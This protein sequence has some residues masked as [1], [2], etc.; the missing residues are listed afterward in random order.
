VDLIREEL[1][2]RGRTVF[3]DR[4]EVQPGQGLSARIEE[5]LRNST[6]FVVYYS[7]RYAMRHAC[8]FELVHAYLADDKEGGPG[9]LMVINPENNRSHIAPVKLVDRHNVMV[10]A[11]D[12]DVIAVFRALSAYFDQDK[13]ACAEWLDQVDLD[14]LAASER[15][16]ITMVIYRM[17][18]NWTNP[19]SSQQEPTQPFE[20][21][22]NSVDGV[23]GHTRTPVPGTVLTLDE[24]D[25]ASIL[26]GCKAQSAPAHAVGL[27]QIHR[28]GGRIPRDPLEVVVETCLALHLLGMPA[29]SSK[30]R[31]PSSTTTPARQSPT[32][33][34]PLAIASPAHAPRASRTT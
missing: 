1:E 2:A 28:A 31:W 3:M 9:R 30:P 21:S 32:R 4:T 27:S 10:Q 15:G 7:P 5:G 26:L 29:T 33:S 13:L 18:H 6:L 20:K 22:E 25:I 8:Q 24:A 11:G 34:C 14:E 19:P 16:G 12:R 17:L 23:V